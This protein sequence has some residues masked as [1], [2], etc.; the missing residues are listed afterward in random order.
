MA[1]AYNLSV[2]ELKADKRVLGSL[3][4]SYFMNFKVK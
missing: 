1:G 4:S 2:G 3:L